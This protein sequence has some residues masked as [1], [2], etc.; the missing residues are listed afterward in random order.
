MGV[1][2]P[3]FPGA[4]SGKTTTRWLLAGRGEQQRK[5]KT[6]PVFDSET[7]SATCTVRRNILEEVPRAGCSLSHTCGD[8]GFLPAAR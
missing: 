2:F 6:G 3:V 1:T 8:L 4:A 7:Y 5:Q